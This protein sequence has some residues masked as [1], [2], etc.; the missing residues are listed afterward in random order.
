MADILSFAESPNGYN[1]YSVLLY[2]LY[3]LRG[4][5]IRGRDRG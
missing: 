4:L 5:V 3:L 2:T 1:I